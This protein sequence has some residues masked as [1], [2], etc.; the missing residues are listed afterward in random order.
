MKVIYLILAACLG[1]LAG[2]INCSILIGKLYG[3]DIRKHGS[4]NAGLTNTLRIMGKTAAI[5][6]FLGDILKGVAACMAGSFLE[7][8]YG[9]FVGGF[10]AVVGH[11]WPVFFGF[12][13]GKGVLTSIT[14]IFYMDYR[15][16]LILLGL[17]LAVVAVSRYVSLGSLTGAVALPILSFIL[18]KG[19]VFT[20]FSC[21][22]AMLVI[23]R[24]RSNIGRLIKGNESK[25]GQ[26][27]PFDSKTA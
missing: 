4:G 25:L 21:L 5:L 1:Y 14:V 22:L 10:A 12:R 26:K 15:I 6:V 9:P 13:G 18:N 2:S 24:H 20:I 27:T 11:N 3:I 16:G 23:L 19:Y 17:F 7:S 8:E